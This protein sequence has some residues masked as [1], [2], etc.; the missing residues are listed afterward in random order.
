MSRRPQPTA[1]RIAEAWPQ[2]FATLPPSDRARA[3]MGTVKRAWSR[4]CRRTI[5]CSPRSPTCWRFRW[6]TP[7]GQHGEPLTPRAELVIGHER[8]NYARQEHPTRRRKNGKR[9]K[10]SKSKAMVHVPRSQTTHAMSKTA[11]RKLD[12]KALQLA[13]TL[14]T[15]LN[16]EI[17]RGKAYISLPNV[18]TDALAL[19]LTDY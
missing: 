11:L 1:L 2:K 15:S 14:V 19:L 3:S 18:P 17:M 16:V 8:M 5:R 13:R 6:N 4:T 12:P 9:V 7:R 10:L